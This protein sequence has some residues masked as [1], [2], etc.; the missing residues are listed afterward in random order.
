MDGP[1][2]LPV[3]I[4]RII[5]SLRKAVDL[6]EKGWALSKAPA[7]HTPFWSIKFPRARKGKNR[8]DDSTML[9][10]LTEPQAEAQWA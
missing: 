9:D 8:I 2:F 4:S 10:T 1:R 5:L 3:M 6:R 7:N